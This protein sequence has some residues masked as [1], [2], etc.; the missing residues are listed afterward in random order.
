M[1]AIDLEPFPV[2]TQTYPR[3]QDW[4]V[5]N[6]LAGLAG[7]LVDSVLGAT[8]QG[9]YWCAACQKETERRIHTCGAA[10]EPLR[11]W[12]WLNNDLVN[13]VSSVAGGLLAAG[14]GLVILL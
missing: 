7:S 4:L 14:L 1:T 9:I 12:G 10:T 11:G 3:K 2:A 13:L 6:A 8:V 5:L